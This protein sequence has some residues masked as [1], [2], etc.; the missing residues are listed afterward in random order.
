MRT[1]FKII[2]VVVK[3]SDE[4]SSGAGF[5]RLSIPNIEQCFNASSED[6]QSDSY[7]TEM[8]ETK[9]K[10]EEPFQIMCLCV[11]VITR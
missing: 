2:S 10:N 9:K 8:T 6:L 4:D 3:Y 5:L 7:K 1:C 11:C